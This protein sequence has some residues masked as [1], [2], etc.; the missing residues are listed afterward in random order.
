MIKAP[1]ANIKIDKEQSTIMLVI[2][3]ATIVTVFCVFSSKALISKAAYQQKVISARD[4]SLT[5][6]QKNL[7]D[8]QT[9]LDQYNKVFIGGSSQNIIGGVSTQSA[10][11]MPPDGSN[12]RIVLDA[13]PTTYDFPALVTSTAS[14]LRKNNVVSPSIVGL[15]A[16]STSDSTPSPNPS[17]NKILLSISGTTTYSGAEQLVKDLER[18]IRPFDA[19]KLS[20]TGNGAINVTIDVTTYYQ[21]A[22][23]LTIVPKK[24]K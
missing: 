13:L 12:P 6:L 14:I 1:K 22:K 16:S 7:K 18:S 9:F 2:A 4:K 3:V 19:A 21:P 24:V 8:A 23:S 20:I 17:P 15:D 11:A 5:Q 10:D